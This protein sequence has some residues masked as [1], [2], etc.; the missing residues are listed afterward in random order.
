MQIRAPRQRLEDIADLVG[1]TA[2][3]ISILL[4]HQK[5]LER[6]RI[7]LVGRGISLLRV[8]GV[9]LEVYRLG[10]LVWCA[11]G[12]VGEGVVGAWLG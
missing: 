7:V 5:Q 9:E 8:G 10:F 1:V 6:L 12:G 11:R 2:L 4:R 3:A